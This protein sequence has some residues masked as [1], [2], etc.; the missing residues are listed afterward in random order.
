VVKDNGRGFDP[1][2]VAAYEGHG[3]RNMEARTRMLG[4]RLSVESEPGK[5]TT[6]KVSVPIET[7]GERGT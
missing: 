1:S 2:R 4:G 6:V 7:L 5:G 3:L